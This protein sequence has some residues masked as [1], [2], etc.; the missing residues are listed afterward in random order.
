MK[1]TQCGSTEF[2]EAKHLFANVNAQ[3]H[4][5]EGG[6][7]VAQVA[8]I[9]AGD[10]AVLSDGFYPVGSITN[11]G[12]IV[13][14]I[15]KKC[16]HIEFFCNT[17]ILKEQQELRLRELEKQKEEDNKRIKKEIEQN[18]NKILALSEKTKDENITVKKQR[19]LLEEIESLK[20]QNKLLKS[21]IK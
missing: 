8:E 13:A 15:C 3:C 2:L 9:Q 21:Q 4:C 16:G 5:I 20:K 6:G 18:S 17:Y 11:Q 10:G 14:Y 1:C 12:E 19:E 7:T